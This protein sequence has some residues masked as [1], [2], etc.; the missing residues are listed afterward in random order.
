MN[1]AGFLSENEKRVAVGYGPKPAG[2]VLAVAGKCLEQR[3]NP[4]HD[5]QG[6]FAFGTGSV[7]DNPRNSGA[8]NRGDERSNI[9]SVCVIS[10]V[11]RNVDS[12]GN[13]S[14]KATYDC[15]GGQTIERIGPGDA[16]GLIRDPFQ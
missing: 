3:F 16:P 15:P 6:R 14:Y 9:I 13:K 11:F 12:F 8:H 10:G 1:D 2:D 4:N 7:E 5:E